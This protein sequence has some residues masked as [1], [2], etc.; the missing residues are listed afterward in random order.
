MVSVEVVELHGIENVNRTGHW[1]GVE[2]VI[3]LA[4]GKRGKC[5]DGY[6]ARNLPTRFYSSS[7]ALSHFF[8]WEHF[9]LDFGKI[10]RWRNSKGNNKKHMLKSKGK[11]SNDKTLKKRIKGKIQRR[12][13]KK[14]RYKKFKGKQF[15]KFNW[16]K[17]W[18]W[19]KK[20][21]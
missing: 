11:Y 2:K 4:C 15:C 14:N 18:N 19:L 16:K 12:K 17:S 7:S 6:D 20:S 1:K 9:V 5:F 3:G 21:I 8:D 10:I 13:S